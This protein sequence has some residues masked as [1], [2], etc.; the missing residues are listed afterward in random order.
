MTDTPTIT[1]QHCGQKREA[2]GPEIAAVKMTQFQP[3]IEGMVSVKLTEGEAFALCKTCISDENINIICAQFMGWAPVK[4]EASGITYWRRGEEE[5]AEWIPPQYS[6][7]YNL[8][9]EIEG[10]LPDCDVWIHNGQHVAECIVGG[11]YLQVR[12][13]TY[14]LAVCNMLVFLL[15]NDHLSMGA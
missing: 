4:D 15:V 13:G 5:Y 11:Q 9:R 14:E 3:K 10:A 12:A 2:K 8:A 1:C 6:R 7:E